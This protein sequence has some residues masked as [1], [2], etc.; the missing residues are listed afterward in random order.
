MKTISPS[1]LQIYAECPRRYSY[2]YVHGREPISTAPSLSF[3][4]VMH[5]ALEVFWRDGKEHVPG[6]LKENA[7][8][9]EETQAAKLVAMLTY[10]D[11]PSGDYEVVSVEQ[12]FE[13]PIIHPSRRTGL[14]S[15]QLG[16]RT[17]AV[18]RKL[19]DGSL[20]VLEHKSTSD[21]IQGFGPYWQRLAID[22]QSSI[23]AMASGA[24]GVL[25]DVLRKPALKLSKGESVE[26]YEAR[27]IEAIA[28]DT[29]RYYQFREIHKTPADLT[30]TQIDVYQ[31]ARLV[32]TSMREGWW[33]KNTGACRSLYGTCPFLDV[34]TGRANLD[35]ETLFRDRE[36]TAPVAEPAEK[37]SE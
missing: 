7:V 32:G 10:Y 36:S 17:D 26:Q 21:D 20:W 35:D 23:Y 19:S 37:A 24:V 13:R 27:M 11:P 12:A 3:G 5:S 25:Y 2:R 9:L 1:A 33:P 18:V 16:G 4:R 6:W 28:A 22:R 29:E 31:A 15:M 14:V 8:Q 34:C 30:E